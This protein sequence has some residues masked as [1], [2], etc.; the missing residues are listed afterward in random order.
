MSKFTNKMIKKYNTSKRSSIIVYFTLRIFVIICMIDQLLRGSLSNAIL[1][2]LSLFL[3]TIPT[4]IEDKYKIDLPNLLEIT[5]YC[6][7]FAAE[8]LGEINNFYGIIPF[9]D[10]ML[11]TL[12][13]FICAGIGFSLV[14]LL[15]E[16]SDNINLSPL[17]V[18]IVG[19]CFS[20][21]V[22][23]CWEFIEYT[24]DQLFLVDM[25][26][27]W[28]V[29]NIGSIKMNETGENKPVII[30]NI[31][32]TIINTKDKSYT[33]KNGYLDIG[34]NDTMK[35]LM[36]NFVGAIVF[37]TL[38]YFYLKHNKDDKITNKFILKKR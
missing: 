18:A 5:I 28:I 24:C 4:F 20:M 35:D 25:Q 14:N 8:I 21:T 30:K 38:G 29:T 11:H 27:D 19:V 12:N 31:Q 34:L 1:C 16:N 7:I 37:S 33:I 3:F 9:W 22:G 32:S 6:F 23:V 36:V 2:L 10:T 17:Y 26:K 15:N 13:G